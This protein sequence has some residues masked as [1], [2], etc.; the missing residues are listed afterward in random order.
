MRQVKMITATIVDP[1]SYSPPL[2][3]GLSAVEPPPLK[4]VPVNR[5]SKPPVWKSFGFWFAILLMAGGVLYGYVDNLKHQLRVFQYHQRILGWMG[6]R[7]ESPK[8]ALVFSLTE[9][10]SPTGF[11]ETNLSGWKQVQD[12]TNIEVEGNMCLFTIPNDRDG[13]DTFS[14]PR[15]YVL[16]Q[17]EHENNTAALYRLGLIHR[18]SFSRRPEVLSQIACLP[19]VPS[20]EHTLVG[21]FRR[22]GK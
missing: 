22:Q 16:L 20:K 11:R 15:Q 10:L 4:Y 5:P 14:S 3:P 13:G 1:P 17:D 7:W 6:G 19:V 21:I 9:S 12:V 18:Y 2:P 8:S